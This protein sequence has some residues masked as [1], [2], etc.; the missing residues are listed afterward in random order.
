MIDARDLSEGLDP[1]VAE[2]NERAG[3]LDYDFSPGS[4]GRR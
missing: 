1:T 2:A 4:S 3:S